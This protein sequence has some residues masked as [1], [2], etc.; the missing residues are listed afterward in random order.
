MD[1]HTRDPDV[2]PPTHG[3]PAG[4]REHHRWE[5]ATLR[6]ATAHGVRLYNAGEFHESHDCFENS[7]LRVNKSYRQESGFERP[8]TSL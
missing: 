2:P 7:W 4:F 5:H 8:P 1:D 6:R 3:S